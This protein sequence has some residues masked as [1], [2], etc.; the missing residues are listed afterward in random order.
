MGNNH[1]PRYTGTDAEDLNVLSY[2]MAQEMQEMDR[3]LAEAE[4]KL[5]EMRE[6]AK[7]K[8]VGQVN[9]GARRLIGICGTICAR[10]HEYRTL[11]WV[12]DHPKVELRG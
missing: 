6:L 8:K 2:R 10:S 7:A 12:L 11:E 1:L 9:D 5:K 4:E 3:L